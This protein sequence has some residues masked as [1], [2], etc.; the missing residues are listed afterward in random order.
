MAVKY[1]EDSAVLD[2]SRH[3]VNL[4][5]VMNLDTDARKISKNHFSGMKKLLKMEIW[6]LN[7]KWG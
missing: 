3:N 5:N 6:R 4:Q 2:M 7:I 1:Y